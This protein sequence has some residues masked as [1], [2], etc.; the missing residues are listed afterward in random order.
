MGLSDFT[1]DFVVSAAGGSPYPVASAADGQTWR[2][3]LLASAMPPRPSLPL[4]GDGSLATVVAAPSDPRVAYAVVGTRPAADSTDPGAIYVTRDGGQ[5]WSFVAARPGRGPVAVDP[6]DADLLYVVEGAAPPT[7]QALRTRGAVTRKTLFTAP[8]GQVERL[9]VVHA[10]GRAAALAVTVSRVVGTG[11]AYDVYRSADAG[12]S[13]AKVAVKVPIGET[14]PGT[15]AGGGL[16]LAADGDL[17][18]IGTTWVFG[19][20]VCWLFR[21]DAARRTW[22]HTQLRLPVTTGYESVLVTAWTPGDAARRVFL[23]GG[24]QRHG[25]MGG[26]GPR[27]VG[28]YDSARDR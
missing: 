13:W 28:T 21:W 7:V 12:R 18:G 6:A 22:R 23:Y 27:I 16:L 9:D 26:I 25:T 20:Q 11:V 17:V 1:T 4:T 10:K 15:F 8:P 5:S 19:Q 3:D 2:A 24:T 14:H